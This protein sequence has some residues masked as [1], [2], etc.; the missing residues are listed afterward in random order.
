MAGELLGIPEEYRSPS[1]TS[2]TGWW[3]RTEEGTASDDAL[4][5]MIELGAMLHELVVERPPAPRVTTWCSLMVSTPVVDDQGVE[6][7]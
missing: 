1:T 7:S 6:H 3:A 4:A 5:A 2:R